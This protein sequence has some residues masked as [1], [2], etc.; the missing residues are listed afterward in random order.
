[1]RLIDADVLIE[2]IKDEL[3]DNASYWYKLIADALIKCIRYQP[4]IESEPVRR[5]RWITRD[6]QTAKC[7]CCEWWQRSTMYYLPDDIPAFSKCYRFCTSY[8]AKME[9][10]SDNG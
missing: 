6:S 2:C 5:G 3:Y 8:G 9:G 1:M 7:S 4:T 10:G